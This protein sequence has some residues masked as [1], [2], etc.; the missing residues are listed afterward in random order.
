MQHYPRANEINRH[1]TNKQNHL[2]NK[3][4]CYKRK[5]VVSNSKIDNTLGKKRKNQLYERT[6]NQAKNK[7]PD[8][9]F[10]WFKIV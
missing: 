6:E 7:L 9:F 2:G 10:V 8:Q 1:S 4:K 3:H 5:V